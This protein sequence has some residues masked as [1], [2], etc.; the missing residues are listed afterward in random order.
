LWELSTGHVS[1]TPTIDAGVA[2][3][4][5]EALKRES[6]LFVAVDLKS[7]RVRWHVSSSTP[8]NLPPAVVDDMVYFV[9]TSLAAVAYDRR[10]G[11]IRWRHQFAG[12]SPYTSGYT[13]PALHGN[14]VFFGG[15]GR[16]STGKDGSFLFALDRFSGR[17]VWRVAPRLS[18]SSVRAEILE[19]TPV[20]SD[21]A[22]FCVSRETLYCFDASGR[23]MRWRW[24][25][26]DGPITAP[27]VHEGVAYVGSLRHL[28]AIDTG[29][30]RILW[31]VPTGGRVST[32]PSIAARAVCFSVLRNHPAHLVAVDIESRRELWRFTSVQTSGMSRA[33]SFSSPVFA[34]DAVFVTSG[35]ELY[36]IG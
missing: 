23:G 19:H 15:A 10:N 14:L 16:M 9:S 18:S 17:E 2:Y 30:G 33:T 13:A 1:S 31:R 29:S 4:S 36:R 25:S 34:G 35:S 3:L 28:V 7:G 21:D 27:A 20:I 24:Q 11:G 32:P 8:E 12:A 5:C 22:V 6:G 26:T